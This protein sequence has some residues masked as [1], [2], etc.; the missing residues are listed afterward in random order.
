MCVRRG[1]ANLWSTD[2]E[3]TRPMKLPTEPA[4][5]AIAADRPRFGH[6]AAARR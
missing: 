6:H 2:S 4:S 1:V 5:V 3:D